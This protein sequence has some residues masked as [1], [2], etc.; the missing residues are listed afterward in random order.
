[1]PRSSTNYLVHFDHLV[2]LELEIT[3]EYNDFNFGPVFDA[4]G[5]RLR[6]LKVKCINVISNRYPFVFHNLQTHLGCLSLLT[7]LTLSTDHC[8]PIDNLSFLS[9]M[10]Y[11]QSFCCDCMDEEKVIAEDLAQNLCACTDLCHL[12]LGY[13]FFFNPVDQL[14]TLYKGLQNSKLTHLG[15]FE[16]IGKDAEHGCAQ[17]LNQFIH[18]KTIGIKLDYFADLN[19]IPSN[20]IMGQWIR[21]LEIRTCESLVTQ[22]VHNIVCFSNLKSIKITDCHIHMED[23]QI[24]I[25]GLSSKLEGFDVCSE[26]VDD[27]Y[28]SFKCLSSCKKLKN[29]HLKNISGLKDNQ[30]YSLLVS[31]NLLESIE[32]KYADWWFLHRFPSMSNMNSLSMDV[33]NALRIPSPILPMLKEVCLPYF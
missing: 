3:P 17:I 23:M 14:Q 26:S 7:T 29:L 31:C 13:F 6:E 21:D 9:H 18:L 12:D 15:S 4:L 5:N 16:I 11:L 25:S 24:L 30:F 27:C 22:D 33:Q 8:K 20:K 19:I 10:K 1:L 32:I 2:S 28:I